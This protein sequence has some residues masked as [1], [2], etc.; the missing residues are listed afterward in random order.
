VQ[1]EE[2]E[3]E[4]P[5]DPSTPSEVVLGMFPDLGRRRARTD[6][7]PQAGQPI[8]VEVE[9][10][11]DEADPLDAPTPSKVKPAKRAPEPV[12]EDEDAADDDEADL[13]DEEDSAFDEDDPEADADFEDDDEDLDDESPSRRTPSA[14]PRQATLSA[15][16]SWGRGLSGSRSM[17][18]ML[19][20]ASRAT[21]PLVFQ[22]TRWVASSR[23]LRGPT[24][25]GIPS[26]GVRRASSTRLHSCRVIRAN[27]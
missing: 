3:M 7:G 9:V 1:W 23:M 15:L 21:L 12:D 24:C 5:R 16:R 14:I 25:C 17:I 13:D 4:E 27:S 6:A 26:R 11:L 10:D 20:P 8:P 18:P 2:T 22:S 19:P